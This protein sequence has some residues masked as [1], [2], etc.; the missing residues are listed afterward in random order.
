[1]KDSTIAG[2]KAARDEAKANVDKVDKQEGIPASNL[3]EQNGELAID[4]A[5]AKGNGLEGYKESAINQISTAADDATSRLTE[6]YNGLSESEQTAAKDA[7]DNAIN[8]IQQSSNDAIDSI[9]NA[10]NKDQVEKL[11]KMQ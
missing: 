11:P 10:T 1:M 3:A 2:I 4:A 8:T 5:E 6:I 9:R 7:F